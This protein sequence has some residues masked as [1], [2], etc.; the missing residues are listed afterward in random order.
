MKTLNQTLLTKVFGLYK[1][2]INNNNKKLI[3]N[4]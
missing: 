2:T 4:I 1:L 3:G